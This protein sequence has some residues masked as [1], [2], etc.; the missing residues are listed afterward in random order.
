MWNWIDE[1]E[2]FPQAEEFK[3]RYFY[4]GKQYGKQAA[5]D[6]AKVRADF[7]AE[8][9]ELVLKLGPHG[10][11][12][13]IETIAT[14]LV[15]DLFGEPVRE[16]TVA[17]LYQDDGIYEVGRRPGFGRGYSQ[18]V[19]DLERERA[20]GTQAYH[21]ADSDSDTERSQGRDKE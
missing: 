14:E 12:N 16:Q 13:W 21:G 3:R 20:E 7:Q 19:A 17:S 2:G 4:T 18:L 5:L 11:S 1:A 6:S 10:P 8:V 15:A 9:N